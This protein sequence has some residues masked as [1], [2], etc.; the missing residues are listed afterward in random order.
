MTEEV[1]KDLELQSKKVRPS[2]EME[3]NELKKL[4]EIR[5]KIAQNLDRRHQDNEEKNYV[6]S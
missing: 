6:C 1:K 2:W 4:N 3:K 5:D